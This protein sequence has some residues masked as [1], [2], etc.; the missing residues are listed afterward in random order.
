[1]APP[2]DC[3]LDFSQQLNWDWASKVSFA[4]KGSRKFFTNKKRVALTLLTS[5]GAVSPWKFWALS[6]KLHLKEN[7]LYKCH[8]VPLSSKQLILDTKKRSPTHAVFL[9]ELWQ[10]TNL[11]TIGPASLT[12]TEAF[13]RR[14]AARVLWDRGLVRGWVW[15]MKWD[16]G[17]WIEQIGLQET[18]VLEEPLPGMGSGNRE[19]WTVGWKVLSQSVLINMKH[20][21]QLQRFPVAVRIIDTAKS[22]LICSTMVCPPPLPS[23]AAL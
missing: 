14:K 12:A 17:A 3:N 16:L 20:L 22:L 18:A 13:P 8:Y 7:A 6:Q 5:H 4:V 11:S 15:F 9:N 1:M 10:H 21:F 23:L 2:G 19:K